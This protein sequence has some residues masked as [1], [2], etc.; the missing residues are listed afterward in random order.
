[1]TEVPI[2]AAFIKLD[3]LLKFS[4]LVETG[5]EAKVL[6]QDGAVLVNGVLCRQRGKKLVPG[7]VVSVGKEE[8][9]VV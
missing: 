3:S 8:V 2:R 7:D 1:M 5:G 6:I 9:K 4:G